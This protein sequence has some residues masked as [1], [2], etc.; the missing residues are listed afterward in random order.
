MFGSLVGI[1]ANETRKVDW[2]MTGT[3]RSILA[4]DTFD[5]AN[6]NVIQNNEPSGEFKASIEMIKPDGTGRHTHPYALTDFVVLN[7]TS[8]DNGNYTNYNGTFTISLREGPAVDVPTTIQKSN[9]NSRFIIKTN[10]ESVDYHSGNSSLIYGISI[11][12]ETIKMPH[13]TSKN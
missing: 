8:T 5:N 7:I 11:N 9:N 2:V 6:E 10:P 4:K 13:F 12:P 3:W 1:T